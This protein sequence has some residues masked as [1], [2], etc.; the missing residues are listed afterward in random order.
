MARLIFVPQY[1][2]PMRYQWWWYYHTANSM[3]GFFDEVITLGIKQRTSAFDSIEKTQEMFSVPK[4]AIDFELAQIKEFM[5]M[6]TKEDDVLFLADLSFPGFF[7]NTLCHKRIKNAYAYLHGTALNKLDYF[8]P[9]GYQK[10]GMERSG[11][12]LFKKV[13]VATDY[14]KEKL[15]SGGFN[16]NTLHTIAFPF[17][18]YPTFNE[19]KEYDVISVARV[20]EQKVT[21]EWEKELES[22][23]GIEITRTS[24][25]T[26]KNFYEYLPFVSK[27]RVLLSTG[28]EETFGL[29]VVDAVTNNCIPIAPNNFSY[30]ELLPREYLYDS[31]D[32]LCEK[33]C[34]ALE[35]RIEVPQLLVEDQMTSFYENLAGHIL[36]G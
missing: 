31:V 34:D 20:C 8:S 33:V 11:G 12:G 3:L 2:T 13:F 23:L 24:N 15:I 6:D 29:Q 21:I 10:W 18:P 36:E 26:F 22:R 19:E 5:E 9:T 32:E 16:P 14:H 27:G 17:S 28:K 4:L 30:V 25:F 35:S 7:A 1:P